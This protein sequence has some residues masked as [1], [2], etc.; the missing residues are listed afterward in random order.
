M[1]LQLLFVGVSGPSSSGKSTVAK[2]LHSVLPSLTLIHLDDFYVPNEKIPMHHT[3]NEQ[4]WDSPDAIDWTQFREYLDKVR[5]T[6]GAALPVE[7]LE[8]RADLSISPDDQKQ[9]AAECLKTLAH[10][11]VVLVDGFLLFHDDDIANLFDVKLYFQAPYEVLKARREARK[12]YNTVAGFW[13]DPPGYFDKIVWPEYERSHSHLFVDAKIG[14]EL[15]AKSKHI[16]IQTK[17]NDGSCSLSD[18]VAW[19]ISSL[20]HA[21]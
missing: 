6:N 12:G 17:V 19:A 16:G 11:H 3:L 20:E 8:L 7:S 5:D 2:A 14:G 4:N 15:T 1:T 13:V 9:L 10:R 18:L 21:A